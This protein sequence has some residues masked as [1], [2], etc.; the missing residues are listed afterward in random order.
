VARSDRFRRQFRAVLVDREQLN[1]LP[2]VQGLLEFL[3]ARQVLVD[4]ERL[5]MRLADPVV[6]QDLVDRLRR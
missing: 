2:A 4:R 6:L 1:R 3:A 5:K